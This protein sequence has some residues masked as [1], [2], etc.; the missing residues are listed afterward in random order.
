MFHG[1]ITSLNLDRPVVDNRGINWKGALLL[2]IPAGGGSSGSA[3]V[4]Q[5]NENIIGFLVGTI[6][7]ANI[8]GIPVSR[9]KAV[10]AA[11]AKNTYKWWVR[12]T[13]I[14]PDGTTK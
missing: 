3:L 1:S 14:N 11:V 4:S 2:D 5:K 7:G 12:D 9:F 6:G 8:V 13:D 10:D